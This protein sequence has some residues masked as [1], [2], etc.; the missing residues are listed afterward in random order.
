M[1][2]EFLLKFVPCHKPYEKTCSNLRVKSDTDSLELWTVCRKSYA[3]RALLPG[4][5]L[6]CISSVATLNE[7][8]CVPLSKFH[9]CRAFFLRYPANCSFS[10]SLQWFQWAARSNVG[11]QSS[12]KTS[13]FSPVNVSIRGAFPTLHSSMAPSNHF[14]F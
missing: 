10:S 7:D 11:S 14:I 1:Y 12:H 6:F 9:S 5:N 2:L 4:S 3:A 8:F 13:L